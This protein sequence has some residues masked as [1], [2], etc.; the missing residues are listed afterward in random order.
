MTTTD[1]LWMK[2][3]IALIVATLLACWA[4]VKTRHTD[5]RPSLMG[6]LLAVAIVACCVGLAESL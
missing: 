6:V 5:G 3:G 4:I 1:L 2:D